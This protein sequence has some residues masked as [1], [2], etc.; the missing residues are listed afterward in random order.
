MDAI[1]ELVKDFEYDRISAGFPG[2]I[3]DGIVHTAP[4]L[5]TE[6]WQNTDLPKLLTDTLGK[7]AVVA[8]DADM[9]G[10]GVI[11][12]Q[13]FEMV[14]TLGTGFGTAFYKNGK[15]L[16]HLEIAHHPI[17]NDETYDQYI[18]KKALKQVGESEWNSRLAYILKVLKRVFNYDHLFLGGGNAKLIN[19]PVAENITIVSNLDGIDGGAKLW[20]ATN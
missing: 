19:F 6:H 13:G 9:L 18:G 8:N 1:R 14:V 2:F 11:R 5:G 12:G 20:D 4:N 15:L 17:K 7:P 16:P 10:L 3:A